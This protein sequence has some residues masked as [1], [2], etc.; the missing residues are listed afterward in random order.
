MIGAIMVYETLLLY[1]IYG[2]SKMSL[3]HSFK[4]FN[5]K[6]KL[7]LY[8]IL[9]WKRR[10]IYTCNFAWIKWKITKIHNL[11]IQNKSKG[12]VISHKFH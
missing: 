5:Y 8:K 9:E 12:K 6:K 4:I 3:K 7:K 1:T 2:C 10:K 11:S